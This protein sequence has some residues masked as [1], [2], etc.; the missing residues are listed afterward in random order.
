MEPFAE[1]L[2]AGGRSNSLGRAGEVLALLRTDPSRVDELVACI[3]ADD[4][5]VRM[6]AVDTFEKLVRED[7]SLGQPHLPHLLGELARSEQASVQWHVAQLL[8]LLDLDDDERAQAVRWLTGR[9]RTTEVDW[10]VAAQ[11]MATLVGLHRDGHVTTGSVVPLLEVQTTHRSASVRRKA[12]R[13]LDEVR[14]RG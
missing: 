11:S 9:L 4:A 14:G 6:R 5:W 13:F 1:V 10:I 3:S 2:A 12:A 8:A 7:P